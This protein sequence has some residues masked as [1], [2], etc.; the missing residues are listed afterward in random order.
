MLA[1]RDE[2]LLERADRNLADLL[3][4]VRIAQSGV[5]ILFGFLLSAGF[6][7][8]LTELTSL[9]SAL[10]T[11]TLSL[12]VLSTIILA[13]PAA[14]HRMTFARGRKQATVRIGHHLFAVGLLTVGLTIVGATTLVV[15]LVLGPRAGSVVTAAVSAY[16][17][18]VWL[19]LPW[20]SRRGILHRRV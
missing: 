16:L 12:S 14:V 6:S 13:A 18:A 11:G 3:Q 5:Q 17:A 2:S 7:R 8:R 1:V 10:Y 19:L 4:E 15:D 20:W 9:Q